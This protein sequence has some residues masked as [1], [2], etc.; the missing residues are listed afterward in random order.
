[1]EDPPSLSPHTTSYNSYPTSPQHP[2]PQNKLSYVYSSWKRPPYSTH[3]T[4]Q[5]P[6]SAV[7]PSDSI[8]RRKTR[9]V[10]GDGNC[11]VQLS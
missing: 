1:M 7:D 11:H 8:S 4:P 5:K 10:V 2:S 9:L 6:R 3:Q